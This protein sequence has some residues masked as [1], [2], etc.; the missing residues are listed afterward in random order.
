MLLANGLLALV[1]TL[2]YFGLSALLSPFFSRRDAPMAYLLAT[3]TIALTI[4]PVRR[5]TR[6]AITRLLHK[7]WQTGQ[8][9]QRDIGAALSRTIDPDALRAL[10]VDDLP[11]RLLIQDA[12]LW[13]L[14]PPDD[15][16]FIAL[17]CLP[18]AAGVTLLAN[19]ASVSQVRYTAGYL[20]IQPEADIDWAAPF[21]ARDVRL[22]IPM[23]V[24]ER[25]VGFYGCGPPQQGRS[26]PPRVLEVLL[27]LA[28]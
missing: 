6:V 18:R 13:M 11:Q 5:R 14:Q 20:L 19:G 21:L 9:L 23:H 4:V 24:G 25:L 12:T 22:V 2:I 1:V 26:Y 15:L 10:L 3:I 7:D 28:P 16:A 27:M 8:E 17:G